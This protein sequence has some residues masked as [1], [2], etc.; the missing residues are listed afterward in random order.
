MS[1]A[2]VSH[3]LLAIED[4]Y[5]SSLAIWRLADNRV[6][7]A[8]GPSVPRPGRLELVGPR[9]SHGGPRDPVIP[10]FRWN[11]GMISL[12]ESLGSDQSVT[13]SAE[14]AVAYSVWAISEFMSMHHMRGTCVAIHHVSGTFNKGGL[15]PAVSYFRN[16]PAGARHER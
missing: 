15:F 4:P 8:S 10:S 6:L 14:F 11:L 7:G 1:A 9:R 16:I 3:S 12:L 5:S 13:T 2:G